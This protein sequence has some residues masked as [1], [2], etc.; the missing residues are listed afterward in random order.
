MLASLI[1][2]VSSIVNQ[3]LDNEMCLHLN[4]RVLLAVSKF[5]D[6][7]YVGMHGIDA[8]GQRLRGC[9]LNL[10]LDKWNDLVRNLCG[11]NHAMAV[12]E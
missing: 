11:I 7:Y 4:G 12:D 9:G 5:H 1:P 2:E 6:K 8:Q 3:G 10:N